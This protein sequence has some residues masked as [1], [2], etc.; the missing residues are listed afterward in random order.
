MVATCV[1]PL[2]TLCSLQHA[3]DGYT[4][5]TTLEYC[6]CLTECRFLR[7]CFKQKD[8]ARY[9]VA[10]YTA[11]AVAA[12]T[13]AHASMLSML[14]V[15]DACQ[16]PLDPL[17]DSCLRAV[18]RW[19]VHSS[20]LSSSSSS[21]CWPALKSCRDTRCSTSDTARQKVP[22]NNDS[23]HLSSSALLQAARHGGGCSR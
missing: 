14:A 18:A 2:D 21:S 16:L 3:H 4:A 19:Q 20:S 8:Q 7:P 23:T 6:D 5:D 12:A 13:G 22:A 1:L 9:G 15:A 10:F 17:L 11:V